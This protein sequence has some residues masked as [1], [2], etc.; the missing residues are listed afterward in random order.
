M[1]IP[2]MITKKEILKGKCYLRAKYKEYSQPSRGA[3]V[4][5]CG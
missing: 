1:L 5:V 3:Q 2:F 4:T